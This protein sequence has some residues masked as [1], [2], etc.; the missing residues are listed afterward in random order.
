MRKIHSILSIVFIAGALAS[1]VPAKVHEELK[2]KYTAC[3]E[4]R[5][6]LNAEK[7][8]WLVKETEMQSELDRLNE[9]QA[10]LMQDT[11]ETGLALRKIRRNYGELN[12]TYELLLE[13]NS[14]LLAENARENQK[15]LT[16][17]EVLQTELQAKED[18]LKAENARLET[19]STQLQMRESRVNELESMISRKDSAVEFL[20]SKVQK[21]LLG[22][23]GKG[24]TV[25]ERNGKVY[26]SLENS[27]L[28]ASGSW[29]VG[30]EGK[31]ALGQ[32]AEVLSQ[33]TDINVLIEG[34]T[35]DDPYNG[36]STVKDN[37][38]LSVMRATSIVKIL[39]ENKNI[40]P[41][42]LTAAGRSEYVP[43][44]PNDSSEN[45]AKN[46]RIEIII[47]PDL[48]ELADLLEE[49]K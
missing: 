16:K 4:E 32:L 37:W 14:T 30:S 43:L 22:F 38:D 33:Q 15:L 27:L 18:S 29:T 45:K 48:S 5:T 10:K 13:N 12:R 6:T 36:S 8:A 40:D 39:S 7:Q 11:T 42:R 23:E 21:A 31:K 26:V 25:E 19:I 9:E 3:E 35:D 20:R 41:K 34:H 2:A 46:R 17:L 1:C 24:L 28:F 44:A 47:T 49:I